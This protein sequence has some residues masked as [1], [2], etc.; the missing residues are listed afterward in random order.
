MGAGTRVVA[1]A[2]VLLAGACA[3]RPPAAPRAAAEPGMLLVGG[4]RFTMGRDDGELNEQPAHDV[5]L[6]EYA[7]DRTEVSAAEFAAFLTAAGNPGEQYFTPDEQATVVL[8]R[9]SGKQGVGFAARPGYE[10][11]PANNV[12]WHGADAYCR[13][14]GKRLPT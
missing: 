11:H 14:R 4:G 12:S 2:L 9:E 7:V 1:L 13:W 3:A 8:L 10:R 5:D 6:E